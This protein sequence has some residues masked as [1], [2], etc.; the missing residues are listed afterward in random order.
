MTPFSRGCQLSKYRRAPCA[1]RK[2]R[3]TVLGKGSGVGVCCRRPSGAKEPG[4]AGVP[5]RASGSATPA[6]LPLLCRDRPSA[7]GRTSRPVTTGAGMGRS[8]PRVVISYTSLL[9]V[10][11]SVCL[12]SA[13]CA[14]IPVLPADA[15]SPPRPAG[16][17][18]M[19]GGGPSIDAR[20]PALRSTL[21][22]ELQSHFSL[23]SISRTARTGSLTQHGP[24]GAGPAAVRP[25]G[26][27]SQPHSPGRTPHRKGVSVSGEVTRQRR[28]RLGRRSC[29]QRR[30]T[31]GDSWV[32]TERLHSSGRKEESQVDTGTA[33]CGVG[34]G[35]ATDQALHV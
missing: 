4:S 24:W 2:R 10:L 15:F 29:L 34:K 26:G 13:E 33:R 35:D 23:F 7:L 31:Q 6:I 32:R 28:Q 17:T 22:G 19:A 5:R 16:Q 18:R 3:R 27:Q 11:E 1:S 21:E 8:V 30:R 12:L 14:A 9:R 20:S 25:A